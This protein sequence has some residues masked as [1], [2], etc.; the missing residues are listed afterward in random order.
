MGSFVLKLI[1]VVEQGKN[2][3]FELDLNE[4]TQGFSLRQSF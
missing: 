3:E 2:H 1:A 4:S